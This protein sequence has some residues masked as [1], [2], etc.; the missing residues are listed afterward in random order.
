MIRTFTK[1]GDLVLD[2]FCGV[3]G[4]LIGCHLSRR[5]GVGVEVNKDWVDIYY[6]LCELES[7]KPLELI[8]GDSRDILKKFIHEKRKQF[9]FILTDIPYWKMDEVEKSK[10]TYKKVGEQSKGVYS[11]KS[12]LSRFSSDSKQFEGIKEDWE[13]LIRDVFSECF[14]L[15][16]PGSY[17]AV[18]I[19]NMYHKGQYFLLN[20]DIVR[21]LAQIGFVLKGEIIWY[22]VNKKLH[23]YG[24]NYSW[25]PSIVHQF[26]MI[27]RKE[28]INN[29]NKEEKEKVKTN[30]LKRIKNKM[31]SEE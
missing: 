1:E 9:D 27:F 8:H 20:A 6:N 23:L 3:G 21:I 13:M 29:L 19:G 25:I 5:T 24:I 10:G 14:K 15:L 4:T 30:N 26:I 16:K 7:L 2:P 17:C 18:F 22:D 11:E 12:K 28:R 31:S